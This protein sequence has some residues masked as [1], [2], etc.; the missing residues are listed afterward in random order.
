MAAAAAS[1]AVGGAPSTLYVGNL[2]PDITEAHLYDRFNSIGTVLS[3]RVCLDAVTR[4]SLG[5]AYVTYQHREDAAAALE[6]L[7]YE[8][9][10]GRACHI[11]LLQR[12]PSIRRSGAG[13]IFIRNLDKSI[14]SRQLFDT[15]SD[16]GEIIFCNLAMDE[17]R[18]SKGY[19]LVC[20]ETEESACSVVELVDG[21]IIKAG[22]PVQVGRFVSGRK[23]REATASRD[24][25]RFTSIYVKNIPKKLNEEALKAK[26]SEFGTI[27][28]ARLP[29]RNENEESLGFG[30]VNYEAPE[31]AA[32]AVER[33][34]GEMLEGSEQPLYAGR[35][36]KKRER[37]RLFKQ[38]FEEFEVLEVERQRHV[39]QS[40]MQTQYQPFPRQQRQPRQPKA[41]AT[42][43]IDRDAL[44]QATP[45]QQRQ[46]LGEALF[47][48]IQQLYSTENI[49]PKLT[50]ML[51]ELDNAELIN[52]IEDPADLQQRVGEAY[53]AYKAYLERNRVEAR[54]NAAAAE[55]ADK[56]AERTLPLAGSV[57]CICNDHPPTH[58]LVPCGHVC[59]CLDPACVE[60]FLQKRQSTCPLCRADFDGVHRI[61]L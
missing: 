50:G 21:K 4:R 17:N 58:V 59:L 7:N 43:S 46:M 37:D 13:S 26:F 47:P 38:E 9:I 45:E 3:T 14:T 23:Q 27:I 8:D 42:H 34:N 32:A 6:E 19:A 49:A 5:Y 16:F 10:N 22:V 60:P 36:M 56:T 29:V 2:D 30:F 12:D 35:A 31:A 54:R 11:R 40:M 55:V 44:L 52:L 28:S 57:C 24:T 48:R 1:S 33:C 15:L 39:R 61:Y 20:Y 53:K 41:H 25:K 18:H 51:L